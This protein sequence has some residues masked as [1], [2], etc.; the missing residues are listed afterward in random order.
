M[1]YSIVGFFNARD[2]RFTGRPI[3]YAVMMHGGLAN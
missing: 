1:T 3:K 2:S